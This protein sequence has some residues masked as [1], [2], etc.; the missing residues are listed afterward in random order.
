MDEKDEVN[1]ARKP[2][3]EAAAHPASESS[4]TERRTDFLN[5]GSE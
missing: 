2:T 1:E 5:F 4:K 3:L